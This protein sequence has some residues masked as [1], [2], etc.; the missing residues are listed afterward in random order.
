MYPLRV[1]TS[2]QWRAEIVGKRDP[3]DPAAL[4]AQLHP[5]AAQMF[6]AQR[7][8]FADATEGD[9]RHPTDQ[10]HERRCAQDQPEFVVAEHAN[11]AV[12][13]LVGL[14]G[15]QRRDRQAAPLDRPGKTAPDDIQ[16]PVHRGQA[17]R[18]GS[19]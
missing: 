4:P 14:N 7:Q 3:M 17:D 11:P 9:E 5:R 10:R 16:F 15:V 8:D 13:R 12:V 19:L 6:S 1:T 2:E 18:L